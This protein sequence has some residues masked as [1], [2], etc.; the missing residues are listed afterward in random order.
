MECAVGGGESSFLS[1]SIPFRYGSFEKE[2]ACT[3]NKYSF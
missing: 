2:V 3:I 1:S